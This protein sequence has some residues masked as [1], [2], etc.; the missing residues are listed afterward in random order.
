MLYI[1]FDKR[2]HLVTV[3]KMLLTP[4]LL[5]LSV[6][7]ALTYLAT[8]LFLVYGVYIGSV[9]EFVTTK[10]HAQL[11]KAVVPGTSKLD[12]IVL[13]LQLFFIYIQ[14]LATLFQSKRKEKS[15]FTSVFNAKN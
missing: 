3:L 7:M 8:L 12:I 14:T 6:Q 11:I 15:Q 9:P 1:I 4:P 2:N 10:Y 5:T 13:F